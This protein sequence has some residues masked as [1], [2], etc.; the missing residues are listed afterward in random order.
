MSKSLQ[1]RILLLGFLLIST[2][3]IFSIIPVFARWA[4]WGWQ[5]APFT[6]SNND[7]YQ[8]PRS[9]APW[10]GVQG[11]YHDEID[12]QEVH[13][14]GSIPAVVLIFAATPVVDNAHEYTIDIDTNGDSDSEYILTATTGSFYLQRLSDY[15]YYDGMGGWEP[16]P[17]Y[18]IV[19]T[20][21]GNNLTIPAPPIS[22][23]T[24]AKLAVVVGYDDGGD[25]LYADYSPNDPNTDTTPTSIPGFTWFLAAFSIC[26]LI[27]L[28]ISKYRIHSPL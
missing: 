2:L 25:T 9:D 27:A 19:Y 16:T 14:N 18:I 12:I 5:V 8:Y 4:S 23:L 3:L 26:T 10:D 28:I 1:N 24:T 20:I 21:S 6:D 17:N 13:V 11:D 7:V 22:T 15:Y